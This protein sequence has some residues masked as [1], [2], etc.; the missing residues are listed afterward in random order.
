MQPNGSLYSGRLDS[1]S[2]RTWADGTVVFNALDG[3]LQCLNPTHGEL[4]ELVFQRPLWSLVELSE[5]FFGA[6]PAL[7]DIDLVENALNVF[8][9]SNLIKRVSV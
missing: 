9:S 2:F 5:A 3:Q 8:V 1:V 4:L 6:T 7:E